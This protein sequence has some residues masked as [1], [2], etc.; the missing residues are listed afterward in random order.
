M[1]NPYPNF[2]CLQCHYK[3]TCTNN[4]CA[5]CCSGRLAANVIVVVIVG[6]SR[7][8]ILGVLASFGGGL[9]PI[10]W[11]RMIPPVTGL[12]VPPPLGP[13]S[14]AGESPP[15]KVLPPLFEKNSILF[16]LPNPVLVPFRTG[17]AAAMH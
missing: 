1:H 11:E 5:G 14:I 8:V 3:E 13:T 15:P 2:N 16:V 17:C 12:S 10:I 4:K 7:N 9:I 6:G